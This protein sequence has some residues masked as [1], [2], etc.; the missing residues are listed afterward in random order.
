MPGLNVVINLYKFALLSANDSPPC[1]LKL[2][3]PT[4]TIQRWISL[5]SSVQTQLLV[6][7]TKNVI[8]QHHAFSVAGQTTWNCLPVA[9]RLWPILFS[10]LWP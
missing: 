8:Q 5:H 6:P 7:R 10:F 3:C 2:C 9:L 4:V 1:G